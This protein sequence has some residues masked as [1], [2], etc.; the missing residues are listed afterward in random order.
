VWIHESSNI[1]HINRILKVQWKEK[2]E[3]RKKYNVLL[4]YYATFSGTCT[5]KKTVKFTEKFWQL[6]ARIFL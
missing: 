1:T 3:N 4:L 2:V 5:V 6:G